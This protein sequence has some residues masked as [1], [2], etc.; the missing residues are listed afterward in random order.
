MKKQLYTTLL[1]EIMEQQASAS[2]PETKEGSLEG[3][4]NEIEQTLKELHGKIAESQLLIYK[5]ELDELKPKIENNLNKI[6]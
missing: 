2:A 3:K 4:L 1:N 5:N 6:E